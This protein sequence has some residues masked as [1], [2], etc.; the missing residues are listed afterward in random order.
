[1]NGMQDTNLECLPSYLHYLPLIF[2]LCAW[3]FCPYVYLIPLLC[4]VSLETHIEI[5]ELGV[6]DGFQPSCG[7]KKSNPKPG[8]LE[9][10]SMTQLLNHLPSLWSEY[11]YYSNFIG[12]IQTSVCVHRE[13]CLKSNIY[14]SLH[15]NFMTMMSKRKPDLQCRTLAIIC[16]PCGW[17]EEGKGGHLTNVVLIEDQGC[18]TVPGKHAEA[19][20]LQCS[21][22]LYCLLFY[23]SSSLK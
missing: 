22:R 10:Q 7:Y 17:H 6:T 23:V 5:T 2:I 13:L 20:L 14:H 9:E 16:R 15:E 4:L 18:W 11:F 19:R 8:P 1:M 3:V 21:C 12:T